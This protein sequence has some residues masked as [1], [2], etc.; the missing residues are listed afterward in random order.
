MLNFGRAT[1]GRDNIAIGDEAGYNMISGNDNIAIG[2]QALLGVDNNNNYDT[3]S[4]NIGIGFQALQSYG[5][6]TSNIAIGNNAGGIIKGSH[7]ICI[8]TSSA[9]AVSGGNNIAL[10]HYAKTHSGNYSIALGYQAQTIG[11]DVIQIGWGSNNKPKT[12]QVWDKNIYQYNDGGDNFTANSF[13][14]NEF[15]GTNFIGDLTGKVNNISFNYTNSKYKLNN[16]NMQLTYDLGLSTPV[17]I[18]ADNA[19]SETD[20]IT[21]YSI[22]EDDLLDIYI[23][24]TNGPAT[25]QSATNTICVRVSANAN[26]GL[27]IPIKFNATGPYIGMVKFRFDKINHILSGSY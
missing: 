16:Y 26:I 6:N 27:S 15:T 5:D 18:E 9:A 22:E 4:Y 8:G 23:N 13:T 11:D 19:Q 20:I 17:S 10:G 1:S 12:I 3:G 25:N 7:N 21:S 14:G 24:Y 2:E